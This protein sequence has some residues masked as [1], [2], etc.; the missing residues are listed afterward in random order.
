MGV[1]IHIPGIVETNGRK[2]ELLS[3]RLNLVSGLGYRPI[4]NNLE[5]GHEHS[6]P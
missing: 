2:S 3:Q 1:L 5:N 4:G 6:L